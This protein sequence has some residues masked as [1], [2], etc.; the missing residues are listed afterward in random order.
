MPATFKCELMTCLYLG[1]CAH[2]HLSNIQATA[3]EPWGM[4]LGLLNSF[5]STGDGI[6]DLCILE[7]YQ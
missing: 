4:Y 1:L 6:Q 2:T 5:S 3:Q 7:V